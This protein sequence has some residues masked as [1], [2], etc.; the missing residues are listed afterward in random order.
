M[1]T[2][3]VEIARTG[4]PPQAI[5]LPAYQQRLF[6]PLGQWKG[7][8]WSIKAY[9]IHQDTSRPEADL[10]D[11][12]VEAAAR[13]HV[14]S[15]LGEA[16]EQGS[17]HHSGFAIIHQGLLANW[18]LFNWWVHGVICCEKL[19]RSPVDNPTRFE[20][21]AGPM[22]ACIWEMVVIEHEKRS[23][24]DH[25]LKDGGHPEAYLDAWLRPGRY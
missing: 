25:V 5:G 14:L 16:D 11:P 21:H 8:G 19:S 3:A 15:R 7:S 6:S 2:S 20:P 17:H 1:R 10:L 23:W 4:Q 24:I 13:N 18:L 12:G 22:V 9:G